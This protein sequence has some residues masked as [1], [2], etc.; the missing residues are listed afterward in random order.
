MSGDARKTRPMPGW[1]AL[2][3]HAGATRY[4]CLGE[5]FG[6]DETIM[7]M[8]AAVEDAELLGERKSSTQDEP[9]QDHPS[10]GRG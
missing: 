4:Q 2:R 3:E 7:F 1:M 6:V 9:H 5:L 10:K 8:P